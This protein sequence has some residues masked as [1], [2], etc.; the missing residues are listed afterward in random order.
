M[1]RYQLSSG[2]KYKSE[3]TIHNSRKPSRKSSKHKQEAQICKTTCP[4]PYIVLTF[5][6]VP[7]M[8]S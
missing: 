1:T 4:L 2:M 8:S 7:K 3:I 5:Q 6:H